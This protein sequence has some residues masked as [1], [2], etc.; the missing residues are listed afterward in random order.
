MVQLVKKSEVVA[1]DGG[2]SATVRGFDQ[3]LPVWQTTG[4]ALTHKN[5]GWLIF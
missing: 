5:G 2:D 4:R 1:P 3:D